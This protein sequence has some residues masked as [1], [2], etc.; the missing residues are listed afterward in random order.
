M[1]YKVRFVKCRVG[2]AA[3]KCKFSNLCK[4]W[5]KFAYEHRNHLS[6]LPPPQCETWS[7]RFLLTHVCNSFLLINL[8]M[9]HHPLEYL[10]LRPNRIVWKVDKSAEWIN[11]SVQARAKSSFESIRVLMSI[12]D[13]DSRDWVWTSPNKFLVCWWQIS[14]VLFFHSKYS[15]IY[16]YRSRTLPVKIVSRDQTV[17]KRDATT[18]PSLSSPF[19]FVG[20][21]SY[22]RQL[23]CLHTFVPTSRCLVCVC[24]CVCVF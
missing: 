9:S 20:K 13:C 23:F 1:E 16:R 11:E 24:V 14:R 8:E 2:I 10:P 7:F 3:K 15:I 12:Y 4:I 22:N 17:R 18:K 21:A 5:L 19:S 6:S